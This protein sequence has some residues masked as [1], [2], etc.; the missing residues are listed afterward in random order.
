NANMGTSTDVDGVF[1]ISAAVQDSLLFS[2]IGYKPQTLYVGKN[3]I[4]TVVLVVEG[5]TLDEVAVVGYGTQR[6]ITLTGAQSTISLREVSK[7]STP[8]ISN[9]IAGKMPGIIT[10]QAS[11]EPGADAAQVF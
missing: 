8:S 3:R 11:G 7:V 4:L 6:K 1:N 5:S 2:S 9:A 10:R